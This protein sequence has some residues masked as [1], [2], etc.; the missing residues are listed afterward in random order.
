MTKT[1]QEQYAL[2]QMIDQQ[3]K[4]TQKQMRTLKMQQEELLGSMQAIDD[5]AKC[6]LGSEILVPVTNGIFV[7]ATLK[8]KDTFTVNIGANAVVKKDNTSVKKLLEDQFKE[9]E[10]VLIQ[11]NHD[12]QEMSQQGMQ[13][14]DE[15]NKQ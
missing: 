1:K 2:L 6:E 10:G 13:I 11:L 15:L 8:E 7:K 14:E 9:V 3:I 5:L 12:I 4:Q